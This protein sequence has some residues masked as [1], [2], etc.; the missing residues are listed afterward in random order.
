VGTFSGRGARVKAIE[1]KPEFRELDESAIRKV[2]K[3]RGPANPVVVEVARLVTGYAANFQEYVK[4]LGYIP[5]DVLRIKP[6]WPIEAVAMRLT[7]QA[8]KESVESGA[9]S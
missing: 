5:S 2:L 9:R 6:R 8:I 1:P 3:D 4:R 7:T